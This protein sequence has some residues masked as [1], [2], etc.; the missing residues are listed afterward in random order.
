MRFKRKE[1]TPNVGDCF[2]VGQVWESPRG[3]LYTVVAGG[4]DH[5]TRKC[6]VAVLRLGSDGKG[7]TVRRAWDAVKDWVI[8]RHK[9]SNAEFRPLAAASSRPVAPGTPG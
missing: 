1:F 2:E 7:R 6:L 4:Y 3:T 8:Y 9:P 5:E